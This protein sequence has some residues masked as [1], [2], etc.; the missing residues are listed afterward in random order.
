MGHNSRKPKSLRCRSRQQ[1]R[2]LNLAFLKTV[3]SRFAPVSRQAHTARAVFQ[4]GRCA[5]HSG[6]AFANPLRSCC[7]ETLFPIV[8]PAHSVARTSPCR[9]TCAP[10][11]VPSRGGQ[12]ELL[13][14][15]RHPIG[16]VNPVTPFV[17]AFVPGTTRKHAPAAS[18]ALLKRHPWPAAL[19]PK[20]WG[21][22]LAWSYW[23]HSHQS[24]AFETPADFGRHRI[25]FRQPHSLRG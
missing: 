25:P 21:P 2:A 3:G 7:S 6:S 5:F 19:P 4:H 10:S 1:N 14:P 13:P 23:E 17:C 18:T 24:A 8:D 16:S 11:P 20:T 12:V 22:G 15:T 9:E